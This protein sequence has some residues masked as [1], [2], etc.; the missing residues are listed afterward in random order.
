MPQSDGS[1]TPQRVQH[2]G[3]GSYTF[4]PSNYA[5]LKK[6]EELHVQ[7]YKIYGPDYMKKFRDGN[8]IKE[9]LK[10]IPPPDMGKLPK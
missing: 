9:Q 7:S 5:E 2:G 1:E 4:I 3:G 10:K 6:G 8:C